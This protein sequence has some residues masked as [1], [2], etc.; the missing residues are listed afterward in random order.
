MRQCH[1]SLFFH[2]AYYLLFINLHEG[3][4]GAH[5]YRFSYLLN[6]FQMH[7]LSSPVSCSE[8]WTNPA[9]AAAP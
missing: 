2:V 8:P 7:L 6:F 4:L 3:C 5:L 9:A 1:H